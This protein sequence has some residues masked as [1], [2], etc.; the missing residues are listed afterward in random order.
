VQQEFV[1]FME[2]RSMA[3]YYV[4]S[5]NISFTVG[6]NDAEGAALWA[7]HRIID[8]KICDFEEANILRELDELL[9][10]SAEL[11][12]EP[13]DGSPQAVP[14][15]PM[16]EGLAEFDETILISEIGLG[17]DDAGAFQTEEIFRQW[18]Q[19]MQAVDRMFDRLG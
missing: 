17:R 2:I 19:L 5:K 11:T 18:R 15:E 9:E 10:D 7:M 4:Q 14:F 3:K 1:L 8:E 12:H 13:I 6:A 16:L